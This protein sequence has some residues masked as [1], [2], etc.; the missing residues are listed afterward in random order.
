MTN[1]NVFRPK[2]RSWLVAALALT[3]S[4]SACSDG[5]DT[6]AENGGTLANENGAA[7]SDDP[8]TPASS[9]DEETQNTLG[10]RDDGDAEIGS[11][12]DQGDST[13][14]AS[15]E[16]GTD[17]ETPP[18][19]PQAPRVVAFDP[20]ASATVMADSVIRG[21]R[22]TYT[23][24]A[25]AGQTMELL[26]TSIEDNAVFDLI[27][28]AGNVLEA[29]ATNTTTVLPDDGVYRVVVGGT[30]G[31]ASYELT[32]VIPPGTAEPDAT[33]TDDDTPEPIR[34][35][36]GASSATVSGNVQDIQAKLY[37]IDVAAGQTMTFLLTAVQNNGVVTVVAPSGTLLIADA[38]L[39]EFV[40]E[41]DGEYS[42]IITA[43]EG[44][45][46]YELTVSVV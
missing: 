39:E 24:A 25:G 2:L 36:S 6:E 18:A 29:E 14:N 4:L 43:T 31:N 41:E 30:R 16:S 28:P 9:G 15:N 19:D 22:H 35:A 7:V 42:L 46:V 13:E 1:L 17:S 10:S 8:A 11:G 33:P 23:V 5:S 12:L 32:I 26:I 20:G 40:L 3:I 44:Q 27:D 38:T 45:A 21:N 37:T 34:F